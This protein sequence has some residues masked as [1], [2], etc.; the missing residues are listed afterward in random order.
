MQP[1]IKILE[2]I[3]RSST[4]NKDEVYTRLYRYLLRTDI[5]YVAYE[6]LYANNG[7]ATKGVNDDTADGFSESKIE[8][9]I[10]SIANGSYQP[11]PSAQNLYCKSKR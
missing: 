5:Y 10:E 4:K 9:I 11:R 1:T 7:A 2:N 8:K 6:N 3:R